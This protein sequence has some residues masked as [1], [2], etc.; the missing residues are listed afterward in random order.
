MLLA[1]LGMERGQQNR[2]WAVLQPI[3]VSGTT[4][5]SDVF[6]SVIQGPYL[7]SHHCSA[8]PLLLGGDLSPLFLL[9]QE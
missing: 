5:V 2:T 3:A 1:F 8:T 7:P 6:I 4:L 9:C